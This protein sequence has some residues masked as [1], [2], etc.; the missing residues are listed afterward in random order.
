MCDNRATISKTECSYAMDSNLTYFLTGG[1]LFGE[2]ASLDEF[3]LATGIA[4]G[5]SEM[6]GVG[7]DTFFRSNSTCPPTS[8]PIAYTLFMVLYAVVCLVGVMGNTL[9]I[10]VVLRFSNMQTV[11]NMY[12]LNLAIADECFLIG[13]P[14]LIATM[15]MRRWVFS[16]AMCKAYM[17]S[18]SIT[19][20]TSSIFLFIMS[21][22]RYIA[23]C[24]HIS[25]PKYRTPLVSRIV[26][27]LA[28]L[29][30]ALI[31]LPIMIYGESIE[32]GPNTFSCQIVWPET[33]EHIRGTAFTLYSL[34]LG[35]VIPLCFIMTFY[36]LVIRKL[37][38]V[39]PKTTNKSRGKRRSHRKVTKLVLTVITVY[40]LCWLPYWI[41]Q[42][43]LITSPVDSCQTR[44][45][46]ILF[47]LVGCL[48]YINSAINPILY[49]YLSENFKK[50]FLKAC[51]C[52]ARAE[53]NA[54]LKLENS[55]MPKRSRTRT[56]SDTTQL[57]T[58]K[59]QH[60]L[61]IDPTTTATTTTTAASTV[62][63]RNPSPPPVQRS[64][65]NYN[66]NHCNN[67]AA[68]VNHSGNNAKNCNNELRSEPTSAHNN[69][70][71]S[72]AFNANSSIAELVQLS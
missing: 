56:N 7:N 37:R 59:V 43:A 24:H 52:A 48:G 42:V 14:F 3:D 15:H 66:N 5:N 46:I 44:L 29:V 27:A 36:C 40:I 4:G 28:W 51:T 9:V 67:S 11:T 35:F 21:A 19:Q 31:M 72:V 13:I 10:Y 41:S 26:S 53:V 61:L 65:L 39:G 49:A 22:D 71:N 54:Q 34:I 63:S 33:H 58:S 45:D 69:N 8:M 12:I 2:N 32:V 20:F 62:S 64:L 55:V 38:N 50:S 70:S 25:S 18:T 47:L 57:T 1:G 23:I 6:V 30:S 68:S 16:G 17:V 60:R